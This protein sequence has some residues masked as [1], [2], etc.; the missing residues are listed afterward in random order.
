MAIALTAELDPDV[1]LVEALRAGD[2]SAYAELWRRHQRWVKGVIFSVVGDANVVEDVAQQAWWLVWER[3]GTLRDSR[4]WR[5]WLYRLV[6]NAAIDAGR[7]RGRDRQLRTELS[8]GA[9]PTA[10]SVGPD[11]SL[12]RNE[13]HAAV[14]DAIRALPAIYRE[15]FV[16]R[17]LED[18]NYR[19]IGETLGLPV[20][21]VETRL[22]RARRLIRDALAGRIGEPEGD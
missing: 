11:R 10:A 9:P 4:R 2:E 17:H 20:D 18:W 6:R 19:Q 3:I 13:Q 12:E 8:M 1:P 21:T 7:E 5:S 22:V 14:L 15:P 16:L